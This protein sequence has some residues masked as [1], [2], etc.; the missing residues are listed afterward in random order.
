[1]KIQITMKGAN[2]H[3]VGDVV[4]IDGNAIPSWA[5]NKCVKVAEKPVAQ[6]KADADAKAKADADAKAKADADAAKTAVTNPAKGAMPGGPS[7]KG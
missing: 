4:E 1:M 5:I 2:G 7:P 3:N 6:A